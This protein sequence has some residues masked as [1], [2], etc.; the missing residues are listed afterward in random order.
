MTF[1]DTPASGLAA[2]NTAP[3]CFDEFLNRGEVFANLGRK[4]FPVL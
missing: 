1:V 4:P 2:A 3:L